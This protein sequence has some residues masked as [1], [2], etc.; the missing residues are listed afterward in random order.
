LD[1][2]GKVHVCKKAKLISRPIEGV[3]SKEREIEAVLET[4]EE[5]VDI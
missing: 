1:K 4:P 2:S 3:D 5:L